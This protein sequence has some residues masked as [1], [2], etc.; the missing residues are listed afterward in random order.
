MGGVSRS[1]RMGALVI[2]TAVVSA[3]TPA[4]DGNSGRQ[5]T[6]PQSQKTLTWAVGVEPPHLQQLSRLGGASQPT[7]AAG[8]IAHE[9][10]AV[11]D[12]QDAFRPQLAVELPSPEKG[13]WRVN[14]DG[15]MVTTWKIHP[16][17]K[18]HDGAPL[19]AAD[20]VFGFKVLKDPAIPTVRMPGL[21]QMATA[22]APDPLTFV[23]EWS[24]FYLEA[25]HQPEAMPLPMHLLETV[26]ERNDPDAFLSNPY[27]STEF[28]GVG[29]YRLR[30]WEPGSHMEF[31]RF[32]AYYRGRP[33][34][35]VI[36]LRF[37][38]DLN[39]MLANSLSETVDIATPEQGNIDAVMQ[40]KQR[41][42]GTENRIV[43]NTTGNLF[44]LYPQFR[45]EVARP[46]NGLT[47]RSV[48]EGLYR[49]I[50]RT[51]FNEVATQG[52]A[53]VADSWF[54]PTDLLRPALEASV[55]Q[56]P[57]DPTRAQQLMGQAGWIRG[58]E[59]V[60]V[61]QQS[62][63]R[64]EIQISGRP[65]AGAE[66]QLEII[67]SDWK[68]LG[69]QPVIHLIPPAQVANREYLATYPGALLSNPPG[70]GLITERLHTSNIA[71]PANRWTGRNASG[72]SNPSAD[73]LQDK[74]LVTIDRAERLSLHRQ[75]LQTMMADLPIMP[76][77]WG[78]RGAFVLRTV[79]GPITAEQAG[80]NI[81]EW[82]KE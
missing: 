76:L 70:D 43:I 44:G 45:I 33:S 19:T 78:V 39:T 79:R 36:V 10:L 52:L 58:T 22:S 16:N 29:P 25:D 63:E 75:L 8:A 31:T 54:K 40:V 2:A 80:W 73:V 55:P 14:P 35:D 24:A 28:V 49:A 12:D 56:F 50:D 53:P 26:H 1:I 6:Q 47:N 59:G 64:F 41:W 82:E 3:C 11:Q 51:A 67:A 38:L 32:D 65:G 37:V 27:F 30:V 48:R 34:I 66:R 74:L 18:W 81:L 5:Q 21:D 77:H 60:F 46:A 20:F 72:Y 71:G 17:V 68:A 23:V 4:G 62:A 69:A 61:H 7:R 13:A 42:E 9:G 57:Y 15:T